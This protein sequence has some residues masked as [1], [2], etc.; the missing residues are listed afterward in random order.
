MILGRPLDS[1]LHHGGQR[2]RAGLGHSAPTV[3]HLDTQSLSF[4]CFVLGV[5]GNCPPSVFSPP[6]L[7]LMMKV[8]NK[9]DLSPNNGRE[10]VFLSDQSVASK[11]S[12]LCQ[13]VLTMIPDKC[14]M[15]ET[16]ALSKRQG[17]QST[18]RVL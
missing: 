6:T 13:L 9:P 14:K 3:M 11:M 4:F 5:T 10:N 12:T 7:R 17:D 16:P 2:G 1:V 18:G 15:C 8:K